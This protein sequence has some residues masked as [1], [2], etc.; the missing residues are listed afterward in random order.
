[1]RR[2]IALAAFALLPVAA[3]DVV[4]RNLKSLFD[5]YK[6]NA[7]AAAEKFSENDYAF[8]PT[9]DVMTVH[10]LIGHLADANYSLCSQMKAEKN[11]DAGGNA[12]RNV[13]KAAAIGALA[14]SFDYCLAAIDA[15]DG[16]M[17][18]KTAAKMPRDKAWV[19][20]HLLD[21]T[22]LHYGN[23]ITYMRLKGIVP[24][25]TERQVRATA[26]AAAKN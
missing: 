13:S 8:R 2:L 23:L 14:T 3:E 22:A 7:V 21:H 19:A 5:G 18:E 20:L 16:K 17:A 25:E 10:E 9:P 26:A 12:K 15:V 4:A 6:L 11:P 1:M 24:P